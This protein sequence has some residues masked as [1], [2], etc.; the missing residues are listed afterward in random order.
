MARQRKT[1]LVLAAAGLMAAACSGPPTS[2]SG[3]Q[4]DVEAGGGG[5]PALPDCPLDALDEAT[6]PVEVTLWYG[7]IGGVTK[8]TMEHMVAAFNASQDQVKVTASDQ[9]SSYAE[10]YRKFESAASANTDQLPDVVLLEN[11]Q[12]QVLADGGLILPAQACMKAS[13]YDIT[14]IEPAVRSAYSVDDVLYPGYANVSSLVL[15][16]NKAHWVE[17]GLD[18]AAPPQT[19][20]EIYEQAKKLKAAGVSDK[21]LAF[22]IS[23]AVFENWLSGDGVDVVNNN[24]GHDGQATEATFDTPEARDALKLLKRMNDEGLVN[25]FA[26]TEGGVDQYLALATQQSSMLIETSGAAVNIAEALGGNLTAADV[27][28]DFDSSLVDRTQLVPGTGMFPGLKAAG[29]VHPGGGGF[30]IVN[31]APP[32]EQAGSWRFLEFMLQPENAKEWHIRGSYLPI[33]KS[34]GDE[35]D[36]QAFWKDEVAGVL[37]KPA[38][39]QLAN[40]DPDEPG[41]LIGPYTDFTDDLENAIEGVLLSG[42]DVDEALASAQDEVTASLERYAGN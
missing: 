36:V 11:T 31:T 12:L 40:A 38:V 18:P 9:G 14:D 23:A 20:E 35:P 6:G 29:Q 10:V 25:V 26:S 16:Y 8:E 17:A 27:G 39:D 34:V 3:G 30:F 15:Y 21:P 32:E 2:G 5:E 28:V 19:L 42:A 4:A 1:M 41:P 37:I 7:G 22:K 13:G 33:V 24:N